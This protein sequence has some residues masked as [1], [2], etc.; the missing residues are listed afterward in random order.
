MMSAK[1]LIAAG[2]LKECRAQLTAEVKAAPSDMGKRTLL[3]QVLA[4]L[5]EWEKAEQHL[6]T[7]AAFN[8]RSAMGVEAY[9]DAIRAEKE[10]RAVAEGRGVPGF[11]SSSTP[12]TELSLMAWNK[13]NEGLLGEAKG[14]YEEIEAQRPSL[15]GTLDGKQFDGFEDTDISLS[16]FLEAIVH[17]RYVWVS[18]ESL[19]ELTVSAP[20]T[21]FDL[22][23]VPAR[24]MTW[25]G[26]NVNCYL[27]VLYPNTFRHA[28]DLVKLGRITDWDW[29]GDTFPRGMGQHVYQVG[30]EEKALLEIRDVTFSLPGRNGD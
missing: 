3:F 15:P 27:P 17:E 29:I 6:N 5:G 7:I 11:L 30:D 1:D 21:L 12:Y 4:F 9:K 10:R 14:L 16:P 2:K 28:D 19:R 25:E 23:W 18:F 24:F 8:P 26:L 20:R 13:V 22:L